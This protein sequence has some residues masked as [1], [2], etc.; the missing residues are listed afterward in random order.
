MHG[1]SGTTMIHE[2][3][4]KHLGVHGFKVFGPMFNDKIGNLPWKD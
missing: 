2:N 3:A 1:P 4:K